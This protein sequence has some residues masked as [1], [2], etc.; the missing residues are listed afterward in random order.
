MTEPP[1][2]TKPPSHKDQSKTT[3]DRTT[4]YD[5]IPLSEKTKVKPPYDRTTPYDKTTL[6]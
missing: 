5:E 6:S 2:M 4:P 1:L 3:H